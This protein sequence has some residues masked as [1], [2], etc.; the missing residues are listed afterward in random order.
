MPNF[1]ISRSKIA[2]QNAGK[3][4]RWPSNVTIFSALINYNM[5]Y[6]CKTIQACFRRV[7]PWKQAKSSIF[8]I[9]HQTAQ[10]VRGFSK[11]ELDNGACSSVWLVWRCDG[12]RDPQWKSSPPKSVCAVSS[13][14]NCV[15]WD[16]VINHMMTLCTLRL[17]WDVSSMNQMDPLS[18]AAPTK[19]SQGCPVRSS[20]SKGP[21]RLWQFV[22]CQ[23][24]QMNPFAI[25]EWRSLR[26][27]MINLQ[28]YG[29]GCFEYL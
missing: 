11:H 24:V 9:A 23:T 29:I 22:P 4:L 26:V 13:A 6:S 28:Q 20:G 19:L 5:I 12:K 17:W 10:T 1:R 14:A 15:A 8:E 25:W 18:T 27:F 3:S 2:A 21:L 16:A 7:W